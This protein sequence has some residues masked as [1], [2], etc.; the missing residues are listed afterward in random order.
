[1]VTTAVRMRRFFGVSQLVL[2]ICRPFAVTVGILQSELGTL[3]ADPGG[4]RAFEFT[5]NS[6]FRVIDDIAMT[7][8][9]RR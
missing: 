9:L 6:H 5:Q 8:K 2:Q 3:H 4:A 1:V 7:V